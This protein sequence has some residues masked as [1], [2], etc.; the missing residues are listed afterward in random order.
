MFNFY[1]KT[2]DKDFGTV[3][4]QRGE[5]PPNLTLSAAA[6]LNE[7]GLWRKN[8]AGLEKAKPFLLA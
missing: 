8:L 1:F 5:K 4:G 3:K 6:S 7:R 2:K